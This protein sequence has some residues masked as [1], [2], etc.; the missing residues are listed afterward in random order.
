MNYFPSPEE[1]GRKRFPDNKGFRK[2]I[3]TLSKDYLAQ[4]QNLLPSNYPQDTSTE[5]AI[6]L[7]TIS[8]ELARLQSSLNAINTDKQYTLTRIE[9]LQ[10]ILGERLFLSDRIAPQNYNDES[11]RNYLLAIKSAYLKGSKKE[12]IEALA[13]EFTGQQIL[14]DEL[15]LKLRQKDTSLDVSDTNMMVVNVLIDQ[16]APGY[17]VESLQDDLNFFINLTKPAHVLYD[18]NLI[19][20]EQIDGNK[21]NNIYYG[22]TGGGC[23]PVY[24]YGLSSQTMYFARQINVLPTSS[25]ATGQIDT[26]NGDLTFTLTNA[27]LV[28]TEP[29]IEGTKIFDVSG[30]QVSFSGL[31]SGQYVGIVYQIIPGDFQFL[32][33]PSEILPTWPSQFYESVYRRP[34]FQ[35]NVQKMMDLNGRFPLQIKTTPTTI[36]DRW[37][38]DTLQPYYEDLRKTC[39]GEGHK[40]FE[41]E[42]NPRRSSPNFYIPGVSSTI[43]GNDFRIQL[44]NTNLTDGSSNPATVS[45][46]LVRLNTIPLISSIASID[47]S[48]GN[49]LLKDSTIFQTGD[50]FNFDYH[51]LQDSSNIDATYSTV[52]GISYWQLPKTPIVTGDG[53]A[54]LAGINDVSLTVNT[55]PITGAVTGLDPLLG[56]IT[57]NPSADF[58]KASELGRYPRTG[59]AWYTVGSEHMWKTVALSDTGRYQIACSVDGLYISSDFGTN[60][61]LASISLPLGVFWMKATIS[62]TGQCMAAISDVSENLYYSSDFGLTWSAIYLSSIWADIKITDTSIFAIDSAGLHVSNDN[63]STWVI[64]T[65]PVNG[66][67]LAISSDSLKITVFG[68]YPSY[69]IYVSSD[70]GDNWTQS[71]YTDALNPGIDSLALSS[72]AQ[73]QTAAPFNNNKLYVSNDFGATFSPVY[74]AKQYYGVSM[75]GDGRLQLVTSMYDSSNKVHASENY[76]ITWKPIRDFDALPVVDRWSTAIS[77]DGCMKALA[78]FDNIIYEWTQDVFSFDFYYGQKHDYPMVLDEI[79]RTFD[80]QSG[81]NSTY[82]IIFDADSSDFNQSVV[83]N[84]VSIGYRYRAYLLHHS[85]VLNSPDTLKLNHFQKPSKRASIINKQD[86]LNHFNKL[87]SPEFLSDRDPIKQ[88][89]DNYLVNGLEPELNLGP[90]TPPFQKTFSYHPNLVYQRKLQDIR[91]NHRLLMYSDLLLKETQ[92]GNES[93]PLSPICDSDRPVIKVGFKEDIPKIHE[94]PPWELFDTV[95]LKDVTVIIPGGKRGVPNLRIIE[96]HIRNNFILREWELTGAALY[97]YTFVTNINNPPQTVFYLPQTMNSYK[98][99]HGNTIYIKYEDEVIDFPALPVVTTDPEILATI[100]DIEVRVNGEEWIVTDLD[101]ITG[102]VEILDYPHITKYEQEFTLTAYDIIKRRKK[103]PGYAIDPQNVTLS[104]VHGTAQY[105]ADDFYVRGSDL[106]WDRGTLG[107]LLAVGD[108]IR[109]SYEVNPLSGATIEFTY[110]IRSSAVVTVIDQDWSRLFDFIDVLPATCSDGPEITLSQRMDEYYTGLDDYSDNI[111]IPYFNKDTR[112]IEEHMFSGPLF[113]YYDI[114]EDEIGSPENFPNALVRMKKPT[115]NTNPLTYMADYDF[116]TDKVVRFRKKNFKEL[117][118]DRS[119]RTTTLIEVMAV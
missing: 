25:G 109:I 107:D 103:L 4:M 29:G 39:R 42:L 35:E 55:T 97:S 3:L 80:T 77:G 72:D 68:S 100:A 82:G 89:D 18:T 20:T 96:K 58:W 74:T 38:Q 9:Y 98:D 32:W 119:Y 31:Q 110:R 73:Y 75:S 88:L 69:G 85:A 26:I 92:T 79:G 30:H 48:A 59:A 70:Q 44:P 63:G 111:M 43:L 118:P 117:L 41:I 91:S 93:V 104:I 28:I 71:I 34:Y 65:L 40:V 10:Q 36:C 23:I 45:D 22:D 66:S 101:P 2:E 19:W 51:Y 87:F 76:G 90:G 116:L 81:Y 78:S 11:Y 83:L 108:K 13:S 57:L 8:R 53:S 106:I 7:K 105:Y 113:E 86:T 54:T 112:Q 47:S 21:I 52:F 95:K 61:N 49:F 46:V 15:Y 14:L 1:L 99:E 12:F 17:S 24:N 67:G 64:K 84:P 16:L 33:Y 60:W 115:S 56:H 37:V 50:I 62:S 94:C 5:M 6:F 27:T 114:R 102:R